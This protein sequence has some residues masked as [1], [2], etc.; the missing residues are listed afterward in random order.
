[1]TWRGVLVVAAA[2]S[3]TPARVPDAT[4]PAPWSDAWILDHAPAY[5]TDTNA[6]RAALEA[7]LANPANM[8]SRQRLMSYGLGTAGWDLLPEWNPRSRPVDAEL[9]VTLATGEIPALPETE[10]PL[11]DGATPTTMDAW[12]ALGRRV[13]LAYP[14]RAEVFMEYGLTQPELAAAVGIERTARGDVPGLVVFTDVDGE[15][16]VGITCA[17]CHATVENGEVVLGQARRNFDYGMLRVT[18][19]REHAIAVHPDEARRMAAWGPGRADVTEDTDE[20]P[21]AIPDLWG[22]RAQRWLTQAG[23]IRHESPIALAIRQET[24]LIDSNHQLVRPPRQLAWAL[25]MYVYALAPPPRETPR[26]PEVL[27]GEKLFGAHCA[28][29]HT[30]A[31]R[32]G[33]VVPAEDIGTDRALATGRGRGTGRYRVPSL[34]GV[35]AGAPYLHHGAVPSLDELLSPARLAPTY[36]GS[37]RGPGPVHGHV[38][39]TDLRPDERAALIAFL[40][41]L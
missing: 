28:R 1:M 40:S 35:G 30:N 23:T 11:W 12:I 22:L 32:G 21:V 37:V 34:I 26:S 24:Q 9:A 20:D 19:D 2:C 8:Y 17:I 31:A 16:R 25:A 10:P 38:Y 13:F 15:A 7:A 39:G 41:T 18:Y 3:R 4:P 5:L 33:G 14:M 36:A 29:C 6:R 27:R